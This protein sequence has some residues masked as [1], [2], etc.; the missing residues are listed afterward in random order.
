MPTIQALG[1]MISPEHPAPP[2]APNAEL[3]RSLGR[4]VRGLSAL[5]WGLPAALIICIATAV[6]TNELGM[7]RKFGLVP[8]LVTTAWLCF[9]LWQ[10][11]Y[12]QKQERIWINAL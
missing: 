9:G 7:L 4:L 12:F 2:A 10:L 6:E 5:F 8:P 1:A 3:L 11:G